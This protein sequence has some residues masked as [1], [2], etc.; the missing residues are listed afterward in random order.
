MITINLNEYKESKIYF[1][2]FDKIIYDNN[3]SKEI[4]LQDHSIN[5]S[6]YRRCKKGE[7][8]I[9]EK[10]ISELCNIFEYKMYSSELIDKIETLFNNIYSD[11]YYKIYKNYDYYINEIEKYLNKKTILFPLFISF[12]L[13]LEISSQKKMKHIRNQTKDLYDELKKYSSFFIGELEEIYD[14]VCLFLEENISENKWIRNYSDGSGYFVLNSRA[15]ENS[16]HMISLFFGEKAREKLYDDGCILRILALNNNMMLSMLN[17]GNYREC[18]NLSIKQIKILQSL[19]MEDYKNPIFKFTLHKFLLSS[20]YLKEY[21][22]VVEYYENKNYY[23][24]TTISCYLV[25][26]YNCDNNKYAQFLN[27]ALIDQDIETCDFINYI[28][29]IITK[30][31]K[32]NLDKLSYFKL[33]QVMKDFFENYRN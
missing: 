22:D 13:F 8:K 1:K 30:K 18:K 19:N 4:F 11:M 17:V 23:S 21:T 25:A 31:Q 33:N 2:L 29:E 6:T 28:N 10:I 9:G 20:L 14:I 32:V 26:L 5:P 16:N 3:I 12:K 15:L 7:L 27:E 24:Y